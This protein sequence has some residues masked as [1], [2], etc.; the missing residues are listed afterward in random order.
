MRRS[1]QPPVDRP[2]FSRCEADAAHTLHGAL[3][4]LLRNVE[5]LT[6]RVFTT[7]GTGAIPRLAFGDLEGGKRFLHLPLARH[8]CRE[9]GLQF[10]LLN[11]NLRL[12]IIE[13]PGLG[14][15]VD[16][17][18][19]GRLG[20]ILSALIDGEGGFTTQILDA[21]RE[22]LLLARCLQPTHRDAFEFRLRLIDGPLRFTDGFAHHSRATCGFQPVDR[23]LDRGR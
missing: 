13:R 5:P 7:H 9:A 18:G 15:K 8:Q 4:R 10:C 2:C 19:Q 14:L 21:F 23:V 12:H 20:E 3:E 16:L 6:G 11:P 1:P 22:Q 17:P